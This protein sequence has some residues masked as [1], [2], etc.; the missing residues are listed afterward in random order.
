MPKRPASFDAMV[1]QAVELQQRGKAPLAELLWRQVLAADPAHAQANAMLGLILAGQ[2]DTTAAI[3][4]LV[5]ALQSDAKNAATW[6][7]LALLQQQTG[8]ADEALASFESA[9]ALR[10]GDA[11]ILDQLGRALQRLDRHAEAVD[12][13]AQILRAQP[14][15]PE[16]LN[17]MGMALYQDGRFAQATDAF[18]QALAL[19]PEAAETLMNLGVAELALLR[20]DAALVSLERALALDP[21]HPDVLLNL[22]NALAALDRYDEAIAIHERLL[23]RHPDDGDVLLNLANALRDTQRH[24]RALA[25][26]DRAMALRVAPPGV[27][28]NRSLCLLAAGDFER[29]WVDYALRFKDP[30]LGNAERELDAPLWSGSET[31]AGKTILLHAEQGLGDTLQFCRYAPVVSA[32]GARVLLEVQP[33]LKG[34]LGSLDG[35]HAL[36]GRGEPLPPHDFHCPLLSLPSALGTR[37]ETIPAQVPYLHADSALLERWRGAVSA[38]PAPRIGIAWTGNQGHP[39]SRRRSVELSM[40]LE[41][42]P[43]AMSVWS[44]LQDDALADVAVGDRGPMLRR[45][46]ETRFVHTAAQMLALDL[47]ITVDTSIAHLAGALGARTWLLLPYA[48]DWRWLAGRVDSPWYP[49]MRL[50]RQP[51]PGDWA[52][53]LAELRRALADDFGGAD[54]AAG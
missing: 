3:D 4:M 50:F 8:R 41:A 38:Q 11:R 14:R 18:R 9:L 29:G 22:A 53:V 49:T 27:R 26:Y 36:I 30:R 13:Y 32:L 24:A 31:L 1:R 54:R 7:N 48:A 35:V 44:L 17:R 25:I 15:N 28:W 37:L 6:F 12:R 10:P 23:A 5:R 47:V 52:A 45:F 19:A 39:D 20:Y 33:P 2:G 43:E 40:L 42:L 21:A 34:V 16:L 51:A 46:E